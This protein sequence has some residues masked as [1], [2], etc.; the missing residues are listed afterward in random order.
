MKTKKKEIKKLFFAVAVIIAVIVTAYFIFSNQN[1]ETA[2]TVT[3]TTTLKIAGTTISTTVYQPKFIVSPRN[4]TYNDGK[5]TVSIKS[6]QI[7]NWIGESVDGN[8]VVE[9]CYSCI[10]FE[11]YDMSFPIGTHTLTVYVEDENGEVKTD[12]VTFT[13]IQI[14]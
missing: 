4:L 5:I 7:S 3:T 11:R 2:T 12:A 8:S 9:E 1:H 14:K 10:S 6:D 13:V